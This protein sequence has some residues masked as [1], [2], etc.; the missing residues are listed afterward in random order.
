MP[1]AKKIDDH[2]ILHGWLNDLFG[3]RTT[4]D[5]LRD[6]ALLDEEFTPD[7]HS[8]ICEFLMSRPDVKIDVE[9]ALP[10]YDANI[11]K[12][13]SAI[14][15]TRHT[16]DRPPLFSILGTSLCRNLFGQEIQ[17]TRRVP[18]PTQHFC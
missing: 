2:L 17:Q 5:L 12:H 16:A 1:T 11:K 8:P 6:I 9:N 13:L 10:I 15:H 4:R 18:A 14:N 7:G 3:Y